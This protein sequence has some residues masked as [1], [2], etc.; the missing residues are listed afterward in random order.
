MKKIYLQYAIINITDINLV[1]YSQV[2]ED[3]ADTVRKNIAGT[4]FWLKW[5]TLPSF[6]QDGSITPL[7]VFNYNEMRA[8]V[9]TPEWSVWDEE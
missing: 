6:I 7:G 1:D 4:E 3:N 2:G 8:I 9:Q 5:D